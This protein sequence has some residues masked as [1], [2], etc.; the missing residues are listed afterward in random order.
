MNNCNI[1]FDRSDFKDIS[2]CLKE[3]GHIG[4]HLCRNELN[5]LV[6]WEFDYS[7]TCGCWD[8]DD[9]YNGGCILYKII[10]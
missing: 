5:E 10:K 2:G 1:I 8:D 4:P 3:N 9:D 7:C 6:E